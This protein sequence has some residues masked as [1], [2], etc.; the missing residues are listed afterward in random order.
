[1]ALPT[2]GGCGCSCGCCCRCRGCGCGCCCCCRCCPTTRG[3]PRINPDPPAARSERRP[4]CTDQSR[5]QRSPPACRGTEAHR[6]I[7]RRPS[8]N[9]RPSRLLGSRLFSPATPPHDQLGSQAARQA[10]EVRRLEW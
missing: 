9:P 5:S 8:R 10:R 2:S 3:A 7:C 6:F 1:M 4:K